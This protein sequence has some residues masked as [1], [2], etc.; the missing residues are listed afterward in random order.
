MKKLFRAVVFCLIL[1][2]LLVLINKILMP[3][4]DFKAKPLEDKEELDYI[5]LGNSNVFYSV[6]PTVI[7]NEEGY[8]GIDLALEQAPLI[9]S[10][11]Q[12][13]EA[14]TKVKTKTVFLDCSAFEYNYGVPAMN[15]LALD[16]IDFGL[17]K[18]ELISNLGEDDENHEIEENP[19]YDKLNYYFPILKFHGRWKEIFEGTIDSKYHEK[20]EHVFM[21][22]VAT[23]DHYQYSKVANWLPT[24]DELGEP[25]MTE[26]TPLNEEYFNKISILCYENDI[27]L[28]L[29]KTPSKIWIKEMSIAMKEFA[30]ENNVTYIEMNDEN[31]L[32]EIGIDEKN[33]F[34][35]FASHFNVYGSEKV[36]KWIA[37][38]MFNYEDYDD[39]RTEGTA[40]NAKW[41]EIY[42]EYLEYRDK[43]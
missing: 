37:T 43:G 4:T 19:T 36:S 17:N 34:C 16:K 28:V 2:F 30:K 32:G 42:K 7:W 13:K 9:I 22:Y 11:Y 6:N 33:D 15:Q 21:G 20:Y 5:M 18:I 14:L 8:T 27:E 12:L 41:N 23:K 38:Y 35:D 10:Y 25:F 1:A 26:V 39:K 24:K 29:I 31:I 40:T 3:N